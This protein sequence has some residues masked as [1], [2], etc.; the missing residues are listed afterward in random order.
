MLKEE[1]FQELFQVVKGQDVRIDYNF[2]TLIQTSILVEFLFNKLSELNPDLKLEELFEEFQAQRLQ[3]LD[4]IVKAA[5]ESSVGED[6]SN[7]VKEEILDKI[8]L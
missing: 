5:Q 1:T 3:E 7:I 4:E 8:D 2:N 6:I